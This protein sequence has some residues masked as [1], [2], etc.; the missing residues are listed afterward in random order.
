MSKIK[1][2]SLNLVIIA[3]VLI[4]PSSIYLINKTILM[5]MQ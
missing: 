1:K 4:I 2:N 3:L 5:K